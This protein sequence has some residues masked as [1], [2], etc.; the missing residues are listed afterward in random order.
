VGS[1][2]AELDLEGALP[3]GESDPLP[4][5]APPRLVEVAVAVVDP[6]LEGFIVA[7]VFIV[8]CIIPRRR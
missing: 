5:G 6:D 7:E 8:L 4:S 3:V 1:H 2:R